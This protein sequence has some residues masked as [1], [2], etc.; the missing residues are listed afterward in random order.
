MTGRARSAILAFVSGFVDTAVF[1][2]MGGLFVAHVTGNFVLLG[3]TVAGANVAG[4]HGAATTLQLIA[5]PIFFVSAMLTPAIAQIVRPAARTAL[6]LWLSAGLTAAAGAADL[7]ARGSAD[8][9]LAMV[10]VAAMGVL[11]AAHR[12]DPTL[13]PPFTVMTGNVTAV[14]IAAARRLHLVRPVEGADKP[15]GAGV[16]LV[17]VLAFALGCAAGALLQPRL[18]LAAMLIPAAL[19]ALALIWRTAPAAPPAAGAPAA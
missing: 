13:G 9:V 18:A 8:A 3:A 6:L 10:L 16:M 12:L 2:H 15:A 7:L 19:V 5:F 17:L 11:N 4:G 1:V 14:A